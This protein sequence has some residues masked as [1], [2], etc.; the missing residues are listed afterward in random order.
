MNECKCMRLRTNENQ[1]LL[2]DVLLKMERHVAKN[3]KKKM[4]WR[5]STTYCLPKSQRNCQARER[6]I[7]LVKSCTAQFYLSQQQT[8]TTLSTK[9]T[10]TTSTSLQSNF[11]AGFHCKKTIKPKCNGILQMTQYWTGPEGPR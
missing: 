4:R 8:R 6:H 3:P 11:I 1:Q 7:E 5:R 2:N 10:K 9:Y